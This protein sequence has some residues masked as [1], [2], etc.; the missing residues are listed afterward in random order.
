[1]Q[2][3]FVEPAL[4]QSPSITLPSSIAHQLVSVLRSHIGDQFVL[5][6][7]SG[8]EYLAEITQISTRQVEAAIIGR[9]QSSTEPNLRLVLYQALLREAKFDWV[10]QKGTELGIASFVPVICERS[11]TAQPSTSKYERWRKVITEAAEQSGR[12]R[13]PQICQPISFTAACT[14]PPARVLGLFASPSQAISLKQAM[15]V[16]IEN[17]DEIR[18][19]IGPEG[20]FSPAEVLCAQLHNFTIVQLGPRILRTETA[21]LAATTAILYAMNEMGG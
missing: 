7:D 4:L 9:V 19:Y 5:L 21:G 13:R 17:L 18:L 1:M 11:I 2:R 12:G 10:L 3:F 14:A 15:R 20:G 16:N 8:W 6:D